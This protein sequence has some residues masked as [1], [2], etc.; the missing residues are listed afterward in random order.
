MNRS[1]PG[2]IFYVV[3]TLPTFI[4][5]FQAYCLRYRFG[6]LDLNLSVVIEAA[7][8]HRSSLKNPPFTSADY[9]D[10]LQRQMLPKSISRL[11]EF[12]LII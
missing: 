6:L 12:E 2:K 11:R 10:L 3:A 9:L 5:F 4:T 8:Q 1:L 7:R